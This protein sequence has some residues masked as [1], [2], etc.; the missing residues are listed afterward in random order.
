LVL[1]D[2]FDSWNDLFI[3]DY[4]YIFNINAVDIA[5]IYS[6]SVIKMPPPLSKYHSRVGPCLP[7]AIHISV[8]LIR[9]LT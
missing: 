7:V 3:I 9:G 5:Y 6:N 4:W 2:S 1:W 8:L